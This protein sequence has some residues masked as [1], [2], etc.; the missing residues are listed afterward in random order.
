MRYLPVGAFYLEA[1]GG[2][3]GGCDR[4]THGAGIAPVGV[5]G[6]CHFAVKRNV[7]RLTCLERGYAGLTADG[8]KLL[9]LRGGAEPETAE[10]L[11]TVIGTEGECVLRDYCAAEQRCRY[12]ECMDCVHAVIVA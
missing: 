11:S 9:L 8:V 5:V 4:L 2:F 10:A 6:I 1:L 7:E 3:E 12:Y